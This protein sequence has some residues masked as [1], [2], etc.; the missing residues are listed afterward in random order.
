[1]FQTFGERMEGME[2]D[3]DSQVCL[4]RGDFLQF[5]LF[6]GFQSARGGWGRTW[7][8]RH[9]GRIS[10]LSQPALLGVLAAH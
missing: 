9:V 1:M 5:L 2:E 6:W 8:R 10:F 3:M 7:T 4:E